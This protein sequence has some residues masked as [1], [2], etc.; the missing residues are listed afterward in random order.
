M[1]HARNHGHIGPREE[2][3]EV[4]CIFYGYCLV[5]VTMDDVDGQLAFGLELS[6]VQ[7]V[8]VL[9]KIVVDIAIERHILLRARIEDVDH[10]I[11][12]PL[13]DDLVVD[14]SIEARHGSPSSD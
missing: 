10:A 13:L 9:Y 3:F 7:A 6:E 4:E 12:V 5:L 1:A 2:L 11:F 14:E 8:S